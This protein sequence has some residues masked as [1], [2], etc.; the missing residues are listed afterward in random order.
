[1]LFFW[2]VWVLIFWTTQ[3]VHHMLRCEACSWRVLSCTHLATHTSLVYGASVSIPKLVLPTLS[4]RSWSTATWGTSCWRKQ[5]WQMVVVLSPLILRWN[6]CVY[7]V[8]VCVCMHECV[9]CMYMYVGAEC[10]HDHM[11]TCVKRA[12][13]WNMHMDALWSSTCF[14]RLRSYCDCT[15]IGTEPWVAR[16]DVLWRGKGNGV[17]GREETCPQRSCC[18]KLH[19]SIFFN[20]CCLYSVTVHWRD[21]NFADII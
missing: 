18:K 13:N 8:S 10:M 5:T 21:P 4:C 11:F 17:L 20:L 9:W 15:F 6:V 3:T 19:V 7:C 14:L 1:M 2:H 16:Q 12:E